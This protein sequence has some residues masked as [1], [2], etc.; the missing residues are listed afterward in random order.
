MAKQTAKKIFKYELKLVE[1]QKVEMPIS[2]KIIH[3]DVQ[4]GVICVWV[5]VDPL[6]DVYHKRTFHIVGTGHDM[7]KTEELTHIGSVLMKTGLFVWH[8][9]EAK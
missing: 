9:F 1:E 5:I 2:A 7:P 8:I 3:I 4:F 6:V